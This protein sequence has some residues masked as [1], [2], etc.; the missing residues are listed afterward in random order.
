MVAFI[1]RTPS[2][3]ACLSRLNRFLV[4]GRNAGMSGG[5]VSLVS[6]RLQWCGESA[7]ATREDGAGPLVDRH[8]GSLA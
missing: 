5:D 1:S 8:D 4:G 7:A 6:Q 3:G 2:I